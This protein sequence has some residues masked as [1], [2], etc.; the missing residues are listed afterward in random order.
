MVRKVTGVAAKRYAKALFELAE[1][2]GRTDEYEETALVLADALKDPEFGNFLTNPRVSKAE[3]L[4]T[5]KESFDGLPEDFEG[6][7]AVALEK[8]RGSEIGAIIGAFIA[9][10]K[11]SRGITEA[12]ITTAYPL[13][14]EQTEAITASISKKLN[15][16]I[17]PV[18]SV[19]RR[20]IG[21]LRVRV[22]GMLYDGTV[23]ASLDRLKKE[24]LNERM[25]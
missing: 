6:L 12:E 10:V 2:R 24:L 20:V 18:L 8:D 1:E 16:R 13:T 21:G 14:A 5:V 22:A 23:G 11:E 19:D 4:K 9:M 25:A 17:V 3:K 15:K 7:I